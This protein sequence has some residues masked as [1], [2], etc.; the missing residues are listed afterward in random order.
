MDIRQLRYFVGVLEAKSLNK[1]SV[2][3]HV[4]QPALSTQIRNLERE[5]GVKLL[6]RHAR[7]IAPTRAGERLGQH[8]YQLLRQVD[9]VRL[10]LS[11]YA[12]APSGDVVMSV[13]PSIPRSVTA[14][15][16]ERCR[17]ELPD[18]QLRIVE[19][20]RQQAQA[21]RLTAGL[22][23]TFHPEEGAP[24]AR[25][26]LVQDELVLVGPAGEAPGRPEI[27]LGEVFQQSLVLPSRPHCLRALVE[28]A[29][30]AGGHDL[31]IACEVDSFEVIKELVERNGAKAILPIAYVWDA[32][33]KRKLKVAKI[34]NPRLQRTLYLLHS[35]RH[36]RSSVID[37]VGCLVRAVI[38]EC[39]D[40]ESFGW[41]RIGLP[42]LVPG[43]PPHDLDELEPSSV[44]RSPGARVRDV[45][46]L[47]HHP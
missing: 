38:F 29:A 21:D 20:W 43:D 37:L 8:A 15:I 40:R 18:V 24:F 6:D 32:A 26:P 9:R 39:I 2:L 17:R 31:R 25:E 46:S 19:R 23:L 13:A 4:A 41:R 12:T 3:L 45:F 35:S 14:A 7:G 36:V 28:A 22:A 33:E 10:D 47:E 16:A 34:R 42:D 44:E 30:L 5:L 27:G 11:G 1:A